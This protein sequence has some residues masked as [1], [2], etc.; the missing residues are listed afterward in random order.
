[1]A[2]SVLFAVIGVVHYWA[3]FNG[4]EIAFNWASGILTGV[5]AGG[6]IY[7]IPEIKTYIFLRKF[8]S[9]FGKYSWKN[10]LR[11]AIPAH[12]ISNV[13][14]GEDKYHAHCD[15]TARRY[16]SEV[17]ISKQTD[18]C[19]LDSDQNVGTTDFSYISFGGHNLTVKLIQ[20]SNYYDNTR[21][22]R[23]KKKGSSKEFICNN[24]IGYDY[25]I[26]IKHHAPN[27][28]KIIW[29]C[30]AGLGIYGTTGAAWFLA[31]RWEDLYKKFSDK[32][33]EVIVKVDA[34]KDDSAT[35]CE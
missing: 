20:D 17:M 25:G 12:T 31:N 9:I 7:V 23:F 10:K 11:L 19:F 21:K 1:L 32:D 24:P 18:I 14:P 4:S 6:I 22:D 13:V 3:S 8:Q 16:I 35:I 28:H 27:N 26:I 33:F 30:V 5:V 2:L 29:I 34:G 15:A